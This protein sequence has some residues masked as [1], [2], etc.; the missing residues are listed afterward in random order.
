[1]T[2]IE[3]TEGTHRDGSPAEELEVHRRANPRM[4]E[5]VAVGTEGVPSQRGR[6]VQTKSKNWGG[7]GALSKRT[8]GQLRSDHSLLQSKPKAPATLGVTGQGPPAMTYQHLVSKW[9]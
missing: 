2:E 9:E 7:G 8:P 4:E 5:E 3:A 1:V 6:D